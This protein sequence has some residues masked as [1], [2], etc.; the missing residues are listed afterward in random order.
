MSRSFSRWFVFFFFV[1][2]DGH[3]RSDHHFTSGISIL[4]IT[5][6]VTVSCTVP[7]IFGGDLSERDLHGTSIR[8]EVESF[9]FGTTESR[10]FVVGWRPL[11][12]VSEL[13]GDRNV[14]WQWLQTAKKND[15]LL[16]QLLRRLL[17]VRLR[18]ELQ[19]RQ[20]LRLAV[21]ANR[22]NTQVTV[23]Y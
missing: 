22:R 23:L 1:R 5:V 12:I 17:N 7:V 2:F 21:L 4:F 14:V 15:Q 10:G 9:G 16:Q 19:T 3:H 13:H 18:P 8:F 20:L 11:V 6:F